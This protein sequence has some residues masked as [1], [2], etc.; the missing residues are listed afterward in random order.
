MTPGA[1]DTRDG[2]VVV[3]LG[4]VG[5]SLARALVAAGTDVAGWDP[6]PVTR[7]AARAAG[8]RVLTSLDDL[9]DVP[10]PLV[11]VA[12]PLRVVPQ[13]ARALSDVLGADAVVT[14]VGSVKGPVRDAMTAAGLAD[15]YVGA[16]PMAG[17]EHTGFLAS[18]PDLLVGV[19]WAVTVHPTTST[20]AFLRVVDLV[21]RVLH[22]T[23]HPLTD[24]V[25]DEAAALVSHVPHILATELLNVVAHSPIRDV[26]LGL[27]AGSFRDGTRVAR[28]DPRRTEAM[29]VENAPW[30]VA[31]LRVVA[32]DL[33]ALADQL[34]DNAPT[35]E[36]FDR[37]D[38]VRRG[39][40]G[41][42]R[43]ETVRTVGLDDGW[44]EALATRGAAGALVTSADVVH[45]TL[46]VIDPDD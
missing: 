11:V 40:T 9:A 22:G 27:A 24:T 34:Q 12:T 15:R 43:T 8:V 41:A 10:A 6:D 28:T 45:G 25:H 39:P 37:A 18:T 38:A 7:E 14:D 23:V 19:R 30:V 32:R 26:A 13:T 2:L 21:T 36:F 4:L 5:G 31:A 3:G 35:G 29:V 16:H 46:L 20:A 17:T 42:A 1:A 44:Q 33:E